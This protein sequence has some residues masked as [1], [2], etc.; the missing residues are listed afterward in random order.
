MIST[1]AMR[2][3]SASTTQIS[4]RV[5][6]DTVV[7]NTESGRYFSLT[8]VGSTIWEALQQAHTAEE[9]ISTVSNAYDVTV[10]TA[11]RDFYT[12]LGAL[13]KAGLVTSS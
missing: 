1:H 4:A 9:L 8:E 3:W 11:A 7:L 12:F 10:E 6:S 2:R 13:Q 5:E